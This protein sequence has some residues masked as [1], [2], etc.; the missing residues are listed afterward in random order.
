[1]G[2]EGTYLPRSGFE[3]TKEIVGALDL[4]Q[5]PNESMGAFINDVRRVLRERERAIDQSGDGDA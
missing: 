5:I 2:T 1:V 3:F 4:T